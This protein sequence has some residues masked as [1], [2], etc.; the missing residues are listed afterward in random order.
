MKYGIFKL[1]FYVIKVVISEETI[2]LNFIINALIN[3]QIKIKGVIEYKITIP[4]VGISNPDFFFYLNSKS[5]N[6]DTYML[7]EC[8]QRKTT[9][10][11][12]IAHIKNQCDS[13]LK[14]SH[15]HLDS[16][17]IPV[18]KSALIFINYMFYDTELNILKKIVRNAININTNKCCVLYYFSNNRNLNQ[19]N[20]PNNQSHSKIIQILIDESNNYRN[21][22]VFKIPFT[23]K[24][25]EPI[26]GLGGSKYNIKIDLSTPFSI[27]IS[28]LCI[29]VIQIKIQQKPGEFTTEDF[30]NFLISN[31]KSIIYIDEDEKKSLIK[32]LTLFL[33]YISK[34]CQIENYKFIKDINTRKFKI[35]LKKSE[36]LIDRI[37]SIEK[38][39]VEYISKDVRQ[40]KLTDFNEFL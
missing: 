30:L 34:I 35:E 29:F 21:W 1:K 12:D 28:H 37:K 33:N 22:E 19:H 26:K 9:S 16:Q 18:I 25:L 8:K 39:L 40:K 3:K 32:K 5:L 31:V 36:T 11:K 38:K 14:I 27:I 24:D 15:N 10:N 4:S 20:F 7:I 6:I 23:L 2:I 13:F 17:K